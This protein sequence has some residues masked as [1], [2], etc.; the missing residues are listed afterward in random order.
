MDGIA[1]APITSL[2]FLPTVVQ[3]RNPATPSVYTLLLH[4]RML[5]A[6]NPE[7]GLIGRVGTRNMRGCKKLA[8]HPETFQR[9]E[10]THPTPPEYCRPSRAGLRRKDEATR[11]AINLPAHFQHGRMVSQF[12]GNAVELYHCLRRTSQFQPALRSAQATNIAYIQRFH[13]TQYPTNN[14]RNQEKTSD[15]L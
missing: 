8:T 3:G 15:G 4:Q 5:C 13:F 6:A 12:R 11:Q 10:T 2:R 1:N 7:R 9:R 14:S